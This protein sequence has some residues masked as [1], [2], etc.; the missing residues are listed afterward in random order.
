MIYGLL[1]I[2]K[3]LKYE[4]TKAITKGKINILG[5][6]F[7]NVYTSKVI[8]SKIKMINTKLGKYFSKIQ[9]FKVKNFKNTKIF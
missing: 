5:L 4:I 2:N 7:T 6:K 3:L 8:I 9:K 1:S